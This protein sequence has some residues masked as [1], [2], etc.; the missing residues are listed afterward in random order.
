MAKPTRYRAN[1][2]AAQCM[3]WGYQQG[4]DYVTTRCGRGT[5]DL[6]KRVSDDAGQDECKGDAMWDFPN[7]YLADKCE[8]GIDPCYQAIYTYSSD[9]R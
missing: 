9:Q 7:A 2:S 1:Y 6:S 5:D 4:C 8:Q 3:S